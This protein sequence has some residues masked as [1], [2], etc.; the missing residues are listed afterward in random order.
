[1][2]NS[3][4]PV[5]VHGE[6]GCG[7]TSVMA[8]AATM[9]QRIKSRSVV[10]LRFLGTTADS[11]SIRLMLSSVCKQ[12]SRA[13]GGGSSHIPQSYKDL[14]TCFAEKLQLANEEL[15]LYVFLDSLDQLSG[16][17]DG[18]QLSWLPTRL[19]R[20][21]HV[22]CS[23]LPDRQYKCFPALQMMIAKPEQFVEVRCDCQ[24]DEC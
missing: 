22:V 2:S 13:Y 21:V 17:N 14:V 5:V 11:S 9:L 6:S 4:D 10:V 16:E 12:I 3:Q 20:H 18:R 1:M 8:T 23:T 7:K 15:P 19:P 24:I